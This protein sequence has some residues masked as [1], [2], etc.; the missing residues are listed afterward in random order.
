[1]KVSFIVWF[2][3]FFGSILLIFTPKIFG[4][5]QVGTGIGYGLMAD[6]YFV[7]LPFL[8]LINDSDVKNS[9]ADDSWFRGIRGIFSRPK[10]QVLPK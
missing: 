8:Y 4:H 9:I 5:T 10:V 2:A 3:E 6:L 7:V 1:M